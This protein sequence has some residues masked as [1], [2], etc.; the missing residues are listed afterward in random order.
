MLR[1]Y[2][3]G[4]CFLPHPSKAL[5]EEVNAGCPWF[6]VRVKLRFFTSHRL[7]CILLFGGCRRGQLMERNDHSS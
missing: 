1:A 5:A 4:L 2:S 3:V 7:R 6:C